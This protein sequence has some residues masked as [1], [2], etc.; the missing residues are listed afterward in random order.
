MPSFIDKKIAIYSIVILV[1]SFLSYYFI[2]LKLT[3]LFHEYHD[4]G[5]F[6]D[7]TKLGDASW[8]L[9]LSLSIFLIFRKY[10]TK[11][12]NQ[13]LF[14]FTTIVASGLIVNILKPIF[15][16]ARPKL[17]FENNEF[18]FN[19][20][21]FQFGHIYSSFPSGHSITSFGLA[22]ALILLFPRYKVIFLILGAIIASSRIVL[23]AHY[24]SDV[25]IGSG[26]GALTSYYLYNYLFKRK[27]NESN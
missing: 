18:G 5:I 11:L 2:D 4:K 6:E 16:R 19:L 7:I 27:I 26:L 9:I 13:A 3:I 15:S 24:L 8:I 23:E 12:A 1:L 25:L 14:I 22:I 20:F 21:D 10:K 17:Y